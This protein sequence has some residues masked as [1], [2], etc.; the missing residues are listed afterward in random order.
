MAFS[1]KRFKE[2]PGWEAATA[3]SNAVKNPR[4]FTGVA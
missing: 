2:I 1:T 3:E 4:R